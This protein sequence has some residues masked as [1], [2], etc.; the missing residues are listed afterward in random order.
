VTSGVGALGH[1][2]ICACF[3][4]PHGQIAVVNLAEALGVRFLDAGHIGRR[5]AG[6]DGNG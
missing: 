2:E 1:E 6:V 4:S 3:G 5:V